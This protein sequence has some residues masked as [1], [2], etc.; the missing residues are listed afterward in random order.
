MP[1]TLKIEF[2]ED[3]SKVT[4]KDMRQVYTGIPIDQ[5]DEPDEDHPKNFDGTAEVAEDSK[6]KFSFALTNDGTSRIFITTATLEGYYDIPVDADSVIFP[7]PSIAFQSDL[8]EANGR[9]DALYE[10]INQNG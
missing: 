8:D 9:I 5:N 7:S 4:V 6:Y 2:A 1:Y 3:L 10:R